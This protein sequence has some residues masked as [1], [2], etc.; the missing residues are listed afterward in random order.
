MDYRNVNIVV[1]YVNKLNFVF[2]REVLKTIKKSKARDLK[3]TS[4]SIIKNKYIFINNMCNNFTIFL[5][6]K[7]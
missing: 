5:E 3:I 7:N 6:L 4:L 1:T 2:H